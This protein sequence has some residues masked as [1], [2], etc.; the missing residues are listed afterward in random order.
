MEMSFTISSE[1]PRPEEVIL[2]LLPL[3]LMISNSS[4]SVFFFHVIFRPGT[5][6]AL[7]VKVVDSPSSTDLTSGKTIGWPKTP[8]TEELNVY[9]L[10]QHSMRAV[11][12]K[13]LLLF[14]KYNLKL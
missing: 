6:V 7:Q 11:P 3:L 5:P 4:C 14:L 10:L 8:I 9:H 2:Y 13:F 1:V 12:T